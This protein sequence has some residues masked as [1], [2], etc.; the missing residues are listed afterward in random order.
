M[1]SDCADWGNDLT[2]HITEFLAAMQAAGF[3]PKGGAVICD[4]KWHQ[5]TAPGDTRGKF[6]GTYSMK[7]VDDGFSIGTFFSRKDPDS[8]H[9][10]HSKSDVKLDPAQ[11]KRIKKQIEEKER[12]KEIADEHLHRKIAARLTKFYPRQPLA[13]NHRYADRKGISLHSVRH[14]KKGDELLIP[15]YG[16]DGQVWSIQRINN[17]K[18]PLNN[19]YLFSD[20]RK[21]GSYFPMCSS[22]EDL[23]I[24]LLCEGFATGASIREA[25]GL[26]VIVAFDSGNLKPVLAALK[27]KYPKSKFVIC[28]DND[29]YTKNVKKEP[30][31]VGLEK[32]HQA[33][34]ALGGAYV[35]A[36]EIVNDKNTDF[37]DLHAAL[38]LAEVKRQIMEA[39]ERVPASTPDAAV[40]DE[41][42]SVPNQ[43]LD[44]G[45]FEDRDYETEWHGAEQ[46][47]GDFDMNFKVLG[48]N[49]DHF[50]YF[51]FKGKQIVALSASAHTLPNLLR[52]D[53][54]NNWM[55]KFGAGGETS[56]K[57][58]VMYAMNA[59]MELAQSRGVFT[60]ETNVRGAGCWI[61][62]N[63][64]VLHCG[65]VLYVDGNK[66]KFEELK[67]EYTYVA[68][69]KVMRPAPEPLS[70]SEAYAL[71]QICEAV[72]WENKLSG[73]LL[74]GWL[75]IA[76]L[77]GAIPFRPH[78][79]INGESQS[80]KSTVIDKIIRGALG[81]ISVNVDGGTTE[82]GVRQIMEV[83]A[84]PMVYDEAEGSPAMAGVIELARKSS[85]GA[86]IKKFGQG[87][88]KVRFA[89]CFSAV[90]PPVNKTSDESRMLFMMIKK[91]LRPTAMEEY[92]DLL[93]KIEK[94]ITHDFPNRMLTRTLQNMDALF[95]NI[96]VFQR[97]ARKVIKGA[98]ASEI[99]GCV[100][101]GL[102]ILSKTDIATP[103]FAE[104][105]IAEHDWTNHTSVEEDTDPIKLL[106][107][108]ASSTLRHHP[109]GQNP[110]DTSIGDLVLMV[111]ENKDD[112]GTADK[113]LRNTG[114]AVKDERVHFASRSK[115]LERVLHDTDWKIKWTNMLS[116]LPGSEK[117]K[118]F[119]FATAVRT[120]GVSIP[121]TIFT[122]KEP[123][124]VIVEIAP[125]ETEIPF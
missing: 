116:N 65:D 96:K 63:R 2:D 54:L 110:R 60:E 92:D 62:E 1:H 21:K 56:E 107:Y 55:N 118:I 120:S 69:G 64:K 77:C 95:E 26:P 115:N 70:N 76:P 125:D 112:D 50:Y 41:S 88:M 78:L 119:Y 102:Y 15:L 49:K 99:V 73:S 36:P 117:F 100:L 32:A 45:S 103:E 34:A 98:R 86:V 3:E 59:L 111:A 18:P 40:K 85:S 37:N 94:T 4:D 25:T 10:W 39:I 16:T 66:T 33:A 89:A 58:V 108:I 68:A 61:D 84:R 81:K 44:G 71:R 8:K 20:G 67:S 90:N 30:W 11:R 43:H 24:F 74:A 12:A 47:R 28:A 9:K 79:Y 17:N 23:S 42:H 7:M 51:P 31:N 113:L 19:K 83:D 91:N 48:Y 35:I 105:W 5:A 93:E 29:A 80:G 97:A 114:I 122:E 22:K 57:K 13:T 38:G 101:A 27:A 123:K 75:V 72:T 52:L 106:Q 109:I 121:L 124:K 14:R 53:N 6:S 82:A 46:Y 87:F 104:K